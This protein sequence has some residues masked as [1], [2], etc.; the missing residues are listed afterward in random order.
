MNSM[1]LGK[2]IA[3]GFAA[4]ILI[5]GILGGMAVF[6]MKAV[7]ALAQKLAKQYVP[8]SQIA[9]DLQTAISQAQIGVRSYGFTAERA[10]LEDARKGM[11][12]AHKHQQAAHKLADEHPELVKLSEH[13]KE[14]DPTLNSFEDFI[15]QTE[16]KNKDLT[17]TREKLNKAAADFIANTGKLIDSQEAKL[18]KEIKAFTEAPKLIERA[19]KLMLANEIRGDGNAARVAVFKSQALRDPKLIEEGLKH[20]ESMDKN[21]EALSAMLT[22]QEDIAELNQVKAGAHSYRD[23]MKEIMADN[24]QLAD[25]SKRRMEVAARL[26]TLATETSAAGMKRTVEAA[27][28]STQKLASASWIMIVGLIVAL[29]LGTA[30]AYFIIW[31]TNKTLTTIATTLGDGANQVAAAAGQ[32]SSASQSLAEGAS[33]QAASLEETSASLEEMTSMTKRNAENAQNAK[34]T[35]V[36]TRRSADTGADQMKT[37]LTSMES[38]KAASEEITKILKNIDEIAFQTNILALNAAVE[39]ARAGEAGAGFAV[40]ADEVRNLAQRC[41][42]AAKETALKIDDSVKKSQEGALISADVAKSFGQI[43]SNVRQLDELVAE[44]A[45]ASTEQSQGIT[46]V[47]TAVTQMD[48]VTQANAATA[49]ES[50]SASEELNAQAETLKEAVT[51]LQQMVGAT[52]HQAV[53]EHKPRANAPAKVWTTNIPKRAE[54]MAALVN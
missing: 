50:A 13:L 10:Y 14:L 18:E 42:A 38:I 2:K 46:Q 16:A 32:V 23:A 15:G 41:A 12:A 29:A 30:V 49:E 27:D 24:L 6:N 47:N 19:R 26:V 28:T 36:Q 34:Q 40:V 1:T 33:E 7:Q 48:K 44:I 8:E 20:F 21:F 51:T 37:L 22:A 25:L 39:A 31:S 43:Q 53:V 54:P 9:G 4:L 35:A 11:E 52:R 3:L 5:A 17:A 45:S